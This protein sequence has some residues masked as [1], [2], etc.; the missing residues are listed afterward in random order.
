VL[1]VFLLS[2]FQVPLFFFFFT[3]LINDLLKE[4]RFPVLYIPE[5]MTHPSPSFNYCSLFFLAPSLSVRWLH[6]SSDSYTFYQLR[7]RDVQLSSV[8]LGGNLLFR[9]LASCLVLA[10]VNYWINGRLSSLAHVLVFI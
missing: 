3:V 9:S 5:S 10:K 1:W 7:V 8:F 6:E 4:R 2:L